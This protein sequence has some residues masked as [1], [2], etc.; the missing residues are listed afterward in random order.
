[1]RLLPESESLH[2]GMMGPKRV[3]RG[4]RQRARI[5]MVLVL[6]LLMQALAPVAFASCMGAK[7]A[8][9][10]QMQ[11]HAHHPAVK[12]PG[13]PT[14]DCCAG[15]A[16]RADCAGS[17]CASGPCLSVS[18]PVTRPDGV[19]VTRAPHVAAVPVFLPTAPPA[20]RFRPPIA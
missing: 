13:Q 4:M 18:I 19:V 15:G 6:S 10:L 2:H 11:S 3:A 12:A 14:H 8:T 9:L 17:D 16:M 20:F 1:M 5:V 7:P